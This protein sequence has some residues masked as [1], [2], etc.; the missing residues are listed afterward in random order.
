MPTYTKIKLQKG[1]EYTG[2][3]AWKP[4]GDKAPANL[5]A[6]SMAFELNTDEMKS[7]KYRISFW[8]SDKKTEKSPDGNFMFE[9]VEEEATATPTA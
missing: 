7:G 8:K 9:R 1:S 4:Q 2:V 3:G 5:L 6:S